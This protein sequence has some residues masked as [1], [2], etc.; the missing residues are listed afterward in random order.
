MGCA[1]SKLDDLPAV[2]LCRDRCAFLEQAIR[3]RYSLADS[4]VAYMISLKGVGGSLRRFFDQD[5]DVGA[6]PSP[7]LNLPPQRK[8]Q[9]EASGSPPSEENHHNHHHGHSHSNSGSHIQ[10]DSD[11]DSDESGSESLHQDDHHHLHHSGK[12]SPYHPYGQMN[13]TDQEGSLSSYPPG[14]MNT[15]FNISYTKNKAPSSV[16]YAQKPMVPETV[17]MGE[18]SSSSSYYPYQYANQNQNQ[19]QSSYPYYSNSG[20][21]NFFGGAPYGYSSTPAMVGPAA[22]VQSEASTSSSAPAPPPPPPP[23]PQTSAWDFLNPFDSEDRYYQPYT[24]SRDSGDVRDVEGI[25]DLEDEEDF[26]HE[27]VKEVQEDKK[28]VDVGG[29]HSYSK[30]VVNDA[31]ENGRASESLYR[32]RPSNSAENNPQEYEVHVVDK[33]VDKEEISGDRGNTP[34]FNVRL[35]SDSEIVREIET[36]FLRASES[37][38]DLTVLLEVGK[39]P[40]KKGAGYHVSSKLLHVTTP[41]ALALQPST[42]KAAEASSIENEGP[43]IEE[44]VGMGSGNLSSTLHK[45]FLW[46]KKLYNEVKVEEKMRLLHDQKSEKLARMDKRGAEAHKIEATRMYIKN[47]STKIRIAIQIVDKISVKINKLRDDE[48]WPQLNELIQGLA[49]F[50]KSLVECHRSQCQ[51]IGQA[52]KL[53]MIASRKQQHPTDAGLQVTLQLEYELLNWISKFSFWIGSQ[54]G[55]VKALN[56]WLMKCLLYVPEETADG[57]VP[58]SPGRIG[59]PPIFVMCFQWAQAMERISEKEVVDSMRECARSVLHLWERDVL[60]MRN[61]MVANKDLERRFRSVEKDDRKVQKEIQA[62]DKRLVL[63]SA[64]G[65]GNGN[66]LSLLGGGNAVYQGDTNKSSSSSLQTSLKRAFETMERFTTESLGAYE[67]LLLRIDE[68]RQDRLSKENERD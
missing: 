15:N 3:L 29:G 65:N 47:L 13:Y 12:N 42:S 58:F 22:S 51:A 36:Q 7:V 41:S 17:Y 26:Q 18:S 61:R 21:G 10:L 56:N 50:W 19:N 14:Y 44:V 33:K 1:S 60:E 5:L 45:L 48:L 9:P 20:Y 59:A 25:P 37:G 28:F 16:V 63:M 53:D 31:D 2:A 55:F 39:M 23:Q 6:P 4:H 68:D 40:Y 46:E 27:V 32:A 62:L 43:E 49:K 8:G 34:A 35:S 66:G 67:E 38:Q 54:K 52:R 57:I 30:G 11:S 64:A 24:S